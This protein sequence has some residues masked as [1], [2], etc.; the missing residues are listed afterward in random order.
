MCQG[1]KSR[2]GHRQYRNDGRLVRIE[3]YKTLHQSSTSVYGGNCLG[4]T[5]GPYT[6]VLACIHEEAVIR[7]VLEMPV[8]HLLEGKRPIDGRRSVCDAF[9]RLFVGRRGDHFVS[10]K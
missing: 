7:R 1:L 9:H 5:Y 8:V 3:R 10:R 4:P 2:T 6:A